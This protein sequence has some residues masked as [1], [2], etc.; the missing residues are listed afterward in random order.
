MMR[1]LEQDAI[2][3][4]ERRKA[5]TAQA[6]ALKQEGNEAFKVENYEEAIAKYAAAI[7]FDPGNALLYTNSALASLKLGD[8]DAALER[9]DVA[10][11]ADE[12]CVKVGDKFVCHV[13]LMHA[14]AGGFSYTYRSTCCCPRRAIRWCDGSGAN[15][16]TRSIRTTHK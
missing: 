10:I 1:G 6:A 13:A 2:E 16:R 7:R 15:R 3:R 14:I 8:Y 5:K 11:R 4:A 9:C 12:R